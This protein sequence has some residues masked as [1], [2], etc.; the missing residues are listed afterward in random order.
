MQQNYGSDEDVEE[1]SYKDFGLE[2][3]LLENFNKDFVDKR[4]D[5]VEEGGLLCDV[6]YL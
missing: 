6:C 3:G 5:P 2:T 4:A 1:E